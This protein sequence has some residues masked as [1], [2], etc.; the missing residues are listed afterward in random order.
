[1]FNRTDAVPTG[2]QWWRFYVT[3]L[4]GSADRLSCSEITM[5]LTLGGADECSGGNAFA[6]SHLWTL[7]PDTCFANDS[8]TTFFAE[9]NSTVPTYIGYAFA[10]DK[11]RS[12]N[13]PSRPSIHRLAP[14]D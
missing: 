1:V 6:R 4:T 10:S 2:K 13:G 12:G 8:T 7:S 11:D 5:A 9:L 14:G 3:N